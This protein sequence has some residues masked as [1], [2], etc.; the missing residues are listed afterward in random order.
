[1]T[2]GSP[3]PPP[4]FLFRNTDALKKL[5]R[6]AR[7]GVPL[8]VRPGVPSPRAEHMRGRP[9]KPRSASS[10]TCRGFFSIKA[11]YSLLMRGARLYGWQRTGIVLSVVWVLCVSMWFFQHIPNANVPGIATVYLQCIGEH[12]AKRRECRARAEWFGEEA[13]SELTAGWP[14]AALGPIL[15]V[16][17][18]M[19]LLAWT[20]RWIR[21]VFQ[22][23][24]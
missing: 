14:L 4:G 15:V 9:R 2:R 6:P 1:M 16:W 8:L 20:V 5:V 17:P 23:R 18:L 21:R 12:N 7:R 19:Y 11:C 22:P 3:V 24:A 10:S 13:R